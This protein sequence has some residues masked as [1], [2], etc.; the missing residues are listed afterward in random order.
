MNSANPV[1]DY[2]SRL[3]STDGFPARWWC[4]Q[5]SAFHGWLYI[6]SDLAIWGAYFAIPLILLRFVT[7][8]KGLPF[9]R[10]F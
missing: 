2:L 10:I 7:G 1:I 4:G 3:L 5:W 6:L 8:K 9:P